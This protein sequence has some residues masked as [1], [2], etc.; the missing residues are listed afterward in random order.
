MKSTYTDTSIKYYRKKLNLKQ[1]ELAEKLGI[2]NTDMSFIETKKMYPEPVMAELLSQA[3]G[4]PIG[5]LYSEEEL[6]LILY[7]STHEN[8][9]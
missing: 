6:S 7:R 1:S 3:L 9:N 8:Q 2:S 5:N 4:V